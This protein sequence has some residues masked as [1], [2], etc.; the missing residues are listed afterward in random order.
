MVVVGGGGGGGVGKYI[1][2]RPNIRPS[3]PVVEALK[4]V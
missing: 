4:I 3:F 2:Y 1:V